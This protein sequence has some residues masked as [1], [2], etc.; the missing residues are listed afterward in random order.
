LSQHNHTLTLPLGV[1]SGSRFAGKCDAYSISIAEGS[2]AR[3]MDISG[4]KFAKISA[5]AVDLTGLKAEAS[6]IITLHAPGATLDG[7][8]FKSATLGMSHRLSHNITKQ[9]EDNE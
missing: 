7:A 8:C 2:V 5:P 3:D 9:D 1:Y 4:L 6:S